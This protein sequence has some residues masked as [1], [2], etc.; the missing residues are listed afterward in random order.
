MHREVHHQQHKQALSECVFVRSGQAGKNAEQADEGYDF[1]IH[2]RIAEQQ[3]YSRK[4]S[5]FIVGGHE[6]EILSSSWLR[7]DQHGETW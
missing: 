2:E 1:F 6:N 4:Y 5:R 3:D 7:V